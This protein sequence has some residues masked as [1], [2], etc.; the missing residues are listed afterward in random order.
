MLIVQTN[1]FFFRYC[2]AFKVQNVNMK[3]ENECNHSYRDVWTYKK[4]IDGDIDNN[5]N[6]DNDEKKQMRH[7]STCILNMFV[8]FCCVTL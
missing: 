7:Y 5:Y 3:W 2:V 6:D 1:F 8:N 4:G